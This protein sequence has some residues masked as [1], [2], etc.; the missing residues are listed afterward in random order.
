MIKYSASS[1]RIALLAG[2]IAL[3]SN[4]IAV[5]AQ[6]V[7]ID[8]AVRNI[9]K[10]KQTSAATSAQNAKVKDPV[11]MANDITTQPNSTLQILLL[12]RSNLTVGPS[13]QLK[14]DRFVYD[15]NKKTS[16]MGASIVKGT[17]RFLS[18]KPMHANPGQTS[19]NTPA[20][21]IGIRGT[22]VEGA[23]GA[24][25]LE[26]LKSQAGFV[27]PANYDP[28]TAT[29]VVLRGPGPNA[30]RGE[31]PG[32]ID[33]TGGGKT[34]TLNTPGQAVF[35]PG[36]G[37]PP[38][39]FNLSTGAFASFDALLRTTP[40]GFSADLRSGSQK[41]AQL[42]SGAGTGVNGFSLEIGRAHV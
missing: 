11:R 5:V 2:T 1:R 42:G 29:L 37:L 6:Q 18:G 41:T 4:P 19:L 27:L 33:V 15:P 31:A 24:D 28:A 38:I 25:A 22:M 35:I 17:F 36:P 21:S 8:A 23:V 3:V 14:V 20:G 7:G 12:D 39:T 30:V 32:Q 40:T 9:V 34:I 13:A 16:A 10:V 26:I